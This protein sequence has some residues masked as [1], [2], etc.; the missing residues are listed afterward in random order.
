MISPFRSSDD[1]GDRKSGSFFS[2]L[3]SAQQKLRELLSYC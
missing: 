1:R 3:S 2:T